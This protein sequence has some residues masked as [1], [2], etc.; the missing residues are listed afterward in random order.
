MAATDTWELSHL[1]DLGDAGV[2]AEVAGDD[3]TAAVD[4]LLGEADRLAFE[5]A[6]E[7]EGKVAEL[8]GPALRE[9][10]ERLAKISDLAGR[11]LNFAHLRFA[12]DTAD[13]ANGALLQSSSE[14]ATTLQT[15]LLFFELEWVAIDDERAEKLLATD[16][17]DF[18]RH[19]LRMERRYRPHLLSAPEER[20]VTE[21]S[22]SGRGAW[23]RLFDELTS[24]IRVELPDAEE[25]VQ[26]DVALAGMFDPDRDRRRA[27]ADSVTA[28]LEPGIRTRAYA[29]NTLL[30]EKAT[31]DRLRSYPHWLA[32]R[33]LSNEASD[34]S[35]EALVEAVRGR[36]ELAR[37][38]YRTKAK[39]LGIERLAD[40]DRMAVVGADEESIEWDAGKR[41]V[42]ETFDSVSPQMGKIA[43]R[44]FDERW[45]DVP[46]RPSK[47]G[48]AFSASTVPSVHPYVMLNWT[49][50]RRDVTTLAHELGHG[51]HQYLAREQGI[52]HQSTPLTVA[53]TASVF[54]EELVFG[55]LL[56]AADDPRSRLNLLA[57]SIEGQIATVFRQIAMNQFED[58]VHTARREEGEL[59][60]ERF[61]ELWADSQSEM[62][63]DSVEITDGYRKWWSYV[64]HFIGTPG[65]VYAYAY[66]Q[67]LALSVY[68][69]Y[70]DRGTEIVPD[71][72]EMLACGGSRSPEELGR[73]VGVDLADP[74]FWDRGLDLVAEQLD[75]A[76]EAA[77]QVL[78]EQ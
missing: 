62:L 61:G 52:F 3:P 14:R 19:H 18:C 74:A 25:P 34:E 48:G 58:R 8:D 41:I 66:G 30:Q 2:G 59:S 47:R 11:A 36:N 72:L 49:D 5:F 43:G 12:A 29:F 56:D 6:G 78:S 60:V 64:P 50:R 46:P 37:R 55:R 20:I 71:Y 31:M 69:L 33:N 23:S 67:L 39:L 45:I 17:L 51:I 16:G 68:R 10:M 4:A 73:I 28:A 27:V 9:A 54:A 32:T 24:A 63:G 40:Y 42:L 15:H 76:E 65:Y 57:E 21:L 75:A 13:P 22:L 44:F 1:I 7:Y 70:L 53:E 38:W 77:E 35:V 26:L